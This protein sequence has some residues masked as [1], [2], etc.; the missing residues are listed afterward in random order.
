MNFLNTEFI[1]K[2]K[3]NK[4]TF[5]TERYFRFIE[6]TEN[7]IIIPKG[8]VGKTI[9]FCRENKIDYDFID[10]R[11][12]LNSVSFSFNAQLKE[13]QQLVMN[14]ISKKDLGVIVA[15]PGSG[16]TVVGLKIIADKKQPA[17]IITHRKQIAEQWIERIEAF[18]GISKNDIGKIGQGRNKS[19]K[20]ITI[21]MIQSLSKEIEK[22]DSKDFLNTFGT[23]IIDECHHIPAE[24]FRNTIAKLQTFYL[25]GLTATPFRKY[26]D[27]KLIFIHLGEIIAEIKS[28]EISTSKTPK[29]II[30]NTELDVPFNSKTDK[31]ETLSKIL[32]HDSTRNKRILQDVI[33]ELKSD[34]KVIIITERKEHIDSLNQYLKQ[35]YETIT[36]S[37]EDS[38][39]AKNSKW[40]L[41]KE[42]NYQ[43]LITTGQFFGEGTDLQ[44][45]NCLFLVYPFSFEGK[46]IQYIGRV[47]R[48][49]VTP[50]IYDYRDIK[51]DYLN[52]MFLKRNV[53]YRKIDKQATLFDEP[54]EITIPA[55]T[56]IL[57]Q[58]IKVSFEKL[59]FRY[60]SI[61]FKL[62]V[63][64]MNT[65]LEFDIENFEI[66]PEFEVLKEYFSKS[67][68]IKNI[69]VAIY[70]EFEKGKL[71]SQLALSNDLKKITK[72]LIESV[73]FKFITKNF[74]GKLNTISEEN[75][76]D[77]NQLQNEN[78][79]K[80]YDSGDELLNDFLQNQN[81]KH[82][83]HLQYL[84]NHHERTILKIRFVLNPF[85]FVFLLAGKTEFHI[86]LETL[87]T[88]EAT[89]IWHF[90]NDKKSL[91]YNLKQVDN[92]LNSIRNNGRQSF[93]ENPPNN[94]SRIL[95]DY[96]NDRKGFVI[97]KDLIEERLI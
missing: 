54:E 37:G 10:E 31:F 41:L 9:R 4:N 84:A 43:V 34:K 40:K 25:Y 79:I 42:G 81:Y 33:N 22:P 16:K 55:N 92:Y 94:F 50:T 89:Y 8:F 59:E 49:K 75:L 68:Q 70:A 88:E 32:I 27:D 95:H 12:K 24:T 57:D 21:A 62:S 3:S 74:L 15:P 30:R 71:I 86:V 85:S 73:K 28:N 83:K 29:I 20:H 39:S 93:I 52:K 72:E 17:L 63:P 26:N 46:L 13:H 36:L 61:S 47:Q 80:L 91:L 19:G 7:S 2:K 48:S 11:K 38:E 65:E 82:Q 44:N 35:S 1:I 58:K 14:S 67:L 23:I 56:F 18:L 6:E 69:E 53:Y 66:R 96:S 45:P 77:I 97:W 64:E 90:D 78:N 5:G 87:N 60:G 51:I 76:L